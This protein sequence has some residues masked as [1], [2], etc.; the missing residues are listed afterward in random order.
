MWK[1]VPRECRVKVSILQ[2][3]TELI[4]KQIM[5]TD[6]YHSFRKLFTSVCTMCDRCDLN[7]RTVLKMFMSP[8]FSIVCRSMSMQMSVPVLP[9]PALQQLYT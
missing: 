4:K 5:S 6:Q 7:F 1:D 3:T 9:T 2:Q 8:L